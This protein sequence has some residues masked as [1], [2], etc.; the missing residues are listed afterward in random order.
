M[1]TTRISIKAIRTCYLQQSMRL[2]KKQNPN[3]KSPRIPSTRQTLAQF[4]MDGI[5][6]NARVGR[7]TPRQITL[8]QLNS[9]R[10]MRLKSLMLGART[11]AAKRTTW[12]FNNFCYIHRCLLNV[13][14]FQPHPFKKESQTGTAWAFRIKVHEIESTINGYY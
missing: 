9:V 2:S 14:H 7:K 5:T 11:F 13:S 10:L 4:T 8:L 12:I 3:K 6:A 1:S